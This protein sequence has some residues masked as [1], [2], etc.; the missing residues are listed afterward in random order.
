M[1]ATEEKMLV[2]LG[3]KGLRMFPYVSLRGKNLKQNTIQF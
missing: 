3:L 2:D 1:D